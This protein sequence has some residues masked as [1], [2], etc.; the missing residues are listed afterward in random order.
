MVTASR[1]WADGAASCA[2]AV[3]HAPMTGTHSSGRIPCTDADGARNTFPEK[4][5]FAFIFLYEDLE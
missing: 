3:P 2:S 4:S 5:F 1:W